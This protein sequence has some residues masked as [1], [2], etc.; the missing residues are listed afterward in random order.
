M[1]SIL[2]VEDEKPIA[3]LIKISLT[4]AGYTCTCVY[5]GLAASDLLETNTY[6]LVLLDIMLP[7]ASGYDVLEYIKPL[8]I[9]VIFITA[10]NSVNDR[11]KGLKMGAEDYIIKPFEIVELLARVE[12]VLRRYNKLNTVI[13]LGDLTIDTV[14]MSVEKNGVNIPL[15][16]KEYE[17]L[18]LFAQNPGVAL[19]RETIYE[20][21]WGG[22]YPC[23]S[24]TVALHV[25]RM[26]K[27][28]GLENSLKT[29]NKVGYRLE[30]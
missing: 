1:I 15:T 3:N 22:D 18:L 12:V 27:K 26:R 6:D 28:L 21:I 24:R 4:K 10:K 16:N 14:A 11:V 9:P 25:Q 20:R 29:I 19:Y 23:D 8:K 2:I 5:D 30:L 13:T 7:G 17:L